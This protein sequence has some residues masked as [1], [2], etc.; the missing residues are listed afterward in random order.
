MTQRGTALVEISSN[1]I[2]P[3]PIEVYLPNVDLAKGG[4]H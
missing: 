1:K 4:D 2:G 3:T